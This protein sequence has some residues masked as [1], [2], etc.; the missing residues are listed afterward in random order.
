MKKVK[1]GK[2]DSSSLWI[3]STLGSINIFSFSD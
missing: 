3:N 2:N 1:R